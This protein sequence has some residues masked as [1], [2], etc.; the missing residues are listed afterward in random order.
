MGLI[1]KHPSITAKE[2]AGKLGLSI[3]TIEKH[4]KSLR[5]ENKI[6]HTGSTKNGE[7]LVIE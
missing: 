2:I 1:K 3:K 5:D 6:R 7:W 4:L